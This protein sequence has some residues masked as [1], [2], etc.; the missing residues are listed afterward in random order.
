MLIRKKVAG[1]LEESKEVRNFAAEKEMHYGI[2][3]GNIS[4]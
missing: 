2:Y 3:K 1:N 4:Y